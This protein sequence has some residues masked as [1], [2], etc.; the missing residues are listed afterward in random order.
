MYSLV[1]KEMLNKQKLDLRFSNESIVVFIFVIST[2]WLFFKFFG[3]L[4]SNSVK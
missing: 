3:Y 4:F 2:F 1:C